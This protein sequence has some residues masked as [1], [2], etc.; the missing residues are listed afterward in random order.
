M[1]SYFIYHNLLESWNLD[2]K[3]QYLHF[4]PGAGVGVAVSVILKYT[5]CLAEK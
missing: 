5:I 2:K 1:S 3:S 4:Y